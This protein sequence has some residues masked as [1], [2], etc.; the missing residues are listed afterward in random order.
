MG[1]EKVEVISAENSFEVFSIMNFQEEKQLE[2]GLFLFV[3]NHLYQNIIYYD[4]MH[5]KQDFHLTNFPH[6]PF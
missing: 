5:H 2:N 1:E 6:V 4:K 3:L